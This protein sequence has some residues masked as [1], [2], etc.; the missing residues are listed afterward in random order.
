M[1]SKKIEVD[2]PGTCRGRAAEGS[3]GSAHTDYDETVSGC[4]RGCAEG[5]KVP[6][7]GGHEKDARAEVAW[8]VAAR[9][10][11]GT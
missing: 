7:I 11:V 1:G 10:G 8:A 5:S 6:G 9:A 4:C 3:M 2:R